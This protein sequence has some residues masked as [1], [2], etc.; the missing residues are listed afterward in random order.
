MRAQLEDLAA[1][2]TTKEEMTRVRGQVLEA[3]SWA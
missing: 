1:D 2:V 3:S